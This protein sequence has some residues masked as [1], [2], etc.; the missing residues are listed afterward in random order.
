MDRGQDILKK[1]EAL[2][3]EQRPKSGIDLDLM[4]DYTRVLYADLLEW[5]SSLPKTEEAVAGKM[6][7]GTEQATLLQ[8]DKA[9]INTASQREDAA[10]NNIQKAA[11]EALSVNKLPSAGA[12]KDDRAPVNT[13]LPP[14]EEVPEKENEDV[15]VANDNHDAFLIH[16]RRAISFEPPHHAEEARK[17]I[18]DGLEEEMPQRPVKPSNLF[19]GKKAAPVPGLPKIGELK[20]SPVKKDIRKA[21]GLNDRY[22]YLNELFGNQ[23]QEYEAALAKLNELNSFEEAKQYINTEI[24]TQYQWDKEEETVQDFY[25]LL[26]QHFTGV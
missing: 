7:L 14:V 26:Q 23:K 17:A 1:L 8:E 18:R 2:Y 25:A 9:E 10:D 15:P 22:L 12:I 16:E 6:P 4:L 21:I 19:S 24:A 20:N 11:P 13:I 3:L 5:R